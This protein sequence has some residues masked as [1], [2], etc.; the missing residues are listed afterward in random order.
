[1]RLGGALVVVWVA[2]LAI[3]ASGDNASLP[4]CEGVYMNQKAGSG[5]G[6]HF[7]GLTDLASVA[8]ACGLPMAIE[9][10]GLLDAICSRLRCAN[11]T[12]L[13]S[14]QN[15]RQLALAT[16]VVVGRQRIVHA[17]CALRDPGCLDRR[18]DAL[19]ARALRGLL[20]EGLAGWRGERAPTCG[21][22]A[23]RAAA[24]APDA[25]DA[26]APAPPAAFD[27]SAHIRIVTGHFETGAPSAPARA[28]ANASRPAR[29]ADAW[30]RAL[31]ARLAEFVGAASLARAVYLAS[32]HALTRDG[33]AAQLRRLGVAACAL[34]NVELRHSNVERGADAVDV[35]LSDWAALAR[36]RVL[37]AQLAVRCEDDDCLGP[38]STK[39]YNAR[40]SFSATA[41]RYALVRTADLTP[42]G[43][44][45][46]R[47]Y[48]YSL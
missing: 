14:S 40:S 24:A 22:V 12:R 5:F 11:A 39:Y 29:H 8:L 41:A 42:H 27:V 3:Q 13:P 9:S 18:D 44:E 33:V 7:D 48:S 2:L 37:V 35:A 23:S 43:L 26:A 15:R 1:M 16:N 34:S 31:A 6:N 4:A 47:N 19:K 10:A 20:G 30:H 17:G 38:E 46:T 45:F 28:S 32:N 21:G 36:S 25:P